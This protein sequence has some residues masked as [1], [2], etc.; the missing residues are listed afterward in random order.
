M[1]EVEKED[2]EDYLVESIVTHLEYVEAFDLRGYILFNPQTGHG[3]VHSKYV[4]L[5]KWVGY[6]DAESTWEPEENLVDCTEVLSQYKQ[7]H[8]LPLYHETFERQF[9]W[10][11]PAASLTLAEVKRLAFKNRDSIKSA[12]QLVRDPP[13]KKKK[14]EKENLEEFVVDTDD[15]DEEYRPS[16]KTKSVIAKQH[17]RLS[18]SPCKVEVKRDKGPK[19][20]L[21]QKRA[22]ED[23]PQ[24]RR[25]R[26][27]KRSASKTVQEAKKKKPDVEER[28]EVI[29][30]VF[31]GA[32]RRT[33]SP[34]KRLLDSRRYSSAERL[35]ERWFHALEENAKEECMQATREKLAKIITSRFAAS[36]D[37]LNHLKQM[38]V[39]MREKDISKEGEPRQYRVVGSS[40]LKKFLKENDIPC[41]LPY[42]DIPV[43]ELVKKDADEITDFLRK[44]D[45]NS[46]NR[47]ID[48]LSAV[49]RRTEC[50]L[51]ELRKYANEQ[52]IEDSVLFVK[53]VRELDTNLSDNDLMAIAL[54]Y[55]ELSYKMTIRILKSIS[56]ERKRFEVIKD[57]VR[58]VRIFGN[59]S[60]SRPEFMD[61]SS[62]SLELQLIGSEL[63]SGS[64]L[65]AV[66]HCSA[67]HWKCRLLFELIS[68]SP[69]QQVFTDSSSPFSLQNFLYCMRYGAHCQKLAFVHGG[70]PYERA[71]I[72]C[73][74]LDVRVSSPHIAAMQGNPRYLF[75]F[76]RSGFDMNTLTSHISPGNI[77]ADMTV[78]ELLASLLRTQS[79][80]M[81]DMMWSPA[82]KGNNKTVPNLTPE[83]KKAFTN[84]IGMIADW[85]HHLMSFVRDNVEQKL[86]SDQQCE[87]MFD[88]GVSPT[89]TIRVS[90][91]SAEYNVRT[92]LFGNVSTPLLSRLL[93]MISKGKT[94]MVLCIYSVLITYTPVSASSSDGSPLPLR[95][96]RRAS[97]RCAVQEA[98]LYD[99]AQNY[100][101]TLIP[102]TSSA[103]D[104]E[105]YF[106]LD[107]ESLK[108]ISTNTTSL[109]LKLSDPAK[110]TFL[111]QFILV[112]RRD[113]DEI[114]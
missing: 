34:L 54:S 93:G 56:D 102:D 5:V 105:W 109:R 103:S 16:K 4:Y 91:L 110:T 27:R 89:H 28:M 12:S 1:D 68:I 111:A 7:K 32:S 36:S 17:K 100:S 71:T 33:R 37:D 76:I 77:D 51:A 62:T 18:Q 114:E 10:K 59:A 78:N 30:Y 11:E 45:E 96:R 26:K 13:T 14:K 63:T 58:K 39:T 40:L 66:S 41:K 23:V 25:G 84:I 65:E 8:G 49:V 85:E 57:L 73:E 104:S 75:E 3:T 42:I 108:H 87:V 83:N 72:E 99:E 55:S 69:F 92:I 64:W 20:S 48:R 79:D 46:N 21:K 2:E 31:D 70:V 94:A 47:E 88:R 60:I 67:A 43:P 95:I 38:I 113:L 86:I 106:V 107:V 74:L 22:A 81:T 97:P 82:S 9:D 29:R 44:L 24:K 90:S 80:N 98:S 52:S 61:N 53:R 101:C 6:A 35:P 112:T 50:S 19:L 15:E